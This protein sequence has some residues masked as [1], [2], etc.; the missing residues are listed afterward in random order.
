MSSILVFDLDDTLYP[1]IA[2]VQ[3]GFS[4]VAAWLESSYGW[5]RSTLFSEMEEILDLS[6]RGSVFDV[7]LRNRGVFQKHVIN[8]CVWIY[9]HHKP[10][11]ISLYNSA[12]HILDRLVQAPYIVTDGHKIVQK[13]KLESL[14]LF[15]RT[16]KA[17]ITHR[18]GKKNAKPSTY[19][20]KRIVE[21]ENC[22]W[23]DLVYVGDNPSKDFVGLNPLGV[24]TLRV[25]TGSYRLTKAA[26]GHDALITIDDLNQLPSV[27]PDLN[28]R[29]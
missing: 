16:K 8:R 21:L 28:W 13:N 3:S 22:A 23:G 1:E 26:R 27:L 25:L 12:Q 19:C 24:R 29:P 6:G 15:A 9:R 10:T 17:F 2:F 18:Y 11:S 4:A 14:G 7:V 5:P 20:F